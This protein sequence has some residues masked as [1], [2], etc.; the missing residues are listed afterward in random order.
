MPNGKQYEYPKEI[1]GHEFPPFIIGRLE[2]FRQSVNDRPANWCKMA[3]CKE[4]PDAETHIYRQWGFGGE[5]ENRRWHSYGTVSPHWSVD[6]VWTMVRVETADWQLRQKPW[7]GEQGQTQAKPAP[8]QRGKP[9]VEVF[10]KEK[11]KT[12]KPLKK[13]AL[14]AI[15]QG[16]EPEPF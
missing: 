5:T 12:K 14:E 13:R 2:Y 11:A 9:L 16:R 1:D 8:R 10:A 3:I 15:E 6:E 7:E 4:S